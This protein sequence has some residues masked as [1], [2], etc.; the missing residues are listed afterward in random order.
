MSDCNAGIEMDLAI[1]VV[2]MLLAWCTEQ[3]QLDFVALNSAII[4]VENARYQYLPMTILLESA[5]VHR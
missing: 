4:A 5:H 1:K 2:L 3:A